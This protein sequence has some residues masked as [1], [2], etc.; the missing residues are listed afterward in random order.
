ME[1]DTININDIKDYFA[2][3]GYPSTEINRLSQVHV[4]GGATLGPQES[5]VLIDIIA[6][7]SNARGAQVV[8]RTGM[9]S[10]P[11]LE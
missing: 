7:M 10:S 1:F 9:P 8:V 3:A 11:T 5:E 4:N 2:L 6:V